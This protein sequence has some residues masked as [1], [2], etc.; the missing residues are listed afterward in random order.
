MNKK[1]KIVFSSSPPSLSPGLLSFYSV[2][3]EADKKLFNHVYIEIWR[4]LF[5]VR[6]S[7]SRPGAVPLL[8]AVDLSRFNHCISYP[9]LVLLSFLYYMS[10]CGRGVIHSNSV[11]KSPLL[12]MLTPSSKKVYLW[13]LAKLGYITRS[14]RDLSRPYLSRSVSRAPAFIILSP[15]GVKLIQDIEKEIYNIMLNTSFDD[16]TG[17]N[18]KSGD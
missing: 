6:S 8:W 3:C 10:C 18:K 7:V 2:L 5:T 15:S 12:S 13:D 16:L 9:Q 1:Q 17:A 11:Y 4:Y 14:T